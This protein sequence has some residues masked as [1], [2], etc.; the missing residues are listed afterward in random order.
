MG[1]LR[2]IARRAHTTRLGAPVST[3]T[4]IVNDWSIFAFVIGL[5]AL[6]LV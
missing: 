5:S 3:I 6:N 2:H 1:A 4:H